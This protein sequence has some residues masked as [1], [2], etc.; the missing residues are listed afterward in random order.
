MTKMTADAQQTWHRQ[1][2]GVRNLFV[3]SIVI[4]RLC[5]RDARDSALGCQGGMRHSFQSILALAGGVARGSFAA[6][7][8]SLAGLTH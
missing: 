1:R 8:I 4:G 2:L 5:S 7:L 3:A 6:A